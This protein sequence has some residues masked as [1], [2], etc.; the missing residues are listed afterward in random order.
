MEVVRT[1]V[2][3]RP[4][5]VTEGSRVCLPQPPSGK[6]VITGWR[7]FR[8]PRLEHRG[9]FRGIIKSTTFTSVSER[10]SDP[11]GRRVRRPSPSPSRH[12]GRCYCRRRPRRGLQCRRSKR[13]ERAFSLG[14][15][16]GTLS[17]CPGERNHGMD[18]SRQGAA[19][20]AITAEITLLVSKQVLVSPVVGW[21]RLTR[22]RSYFWRGRPRSLLSNFSAGPQSTHDAQANSSKIPP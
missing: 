15:R 9:S 3:A 12:T 8:P 6:A 10:K 11:R 19:I 18:E 17:L 7:Q 13:R 16:R 4:E 2:A 20:T 5:A 22:E 1:A 14:H 21:S